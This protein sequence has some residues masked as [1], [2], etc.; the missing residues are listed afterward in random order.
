MFEV[1]SAWLVGVMTVS[2]VWIAW[3]AR[4]VVP[5]LSFVCVAVLPVPVY[6]F[7]DIVAGLLR[8]R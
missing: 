4:R 5:F 3:Q 6:V 2:L 7:V 8:N 1:I